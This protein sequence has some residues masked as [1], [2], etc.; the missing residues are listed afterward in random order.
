MQAPKSTKSEQTISSQ[1]SLSSYFFS[2]DQ[3]DLMII[4]KEILAQNN[5]QQSNNLT[6]GASTSLRN[7]WE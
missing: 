1:E 7:Q 4:N 6:Q 2:N 5:R 3:S